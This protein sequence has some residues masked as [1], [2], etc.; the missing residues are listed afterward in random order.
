MKAL[1]D[2]DWVLEFNTIFATHQSETTLSRAR[3]GNHTAAFIRYL[4]R[5]TEGATV[6]CLQYQGP[7]EGSS[8][9]AE[10]PTRLRVVFH[11]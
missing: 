3:F 2:P 9:V 4:I 11:W 1:S 10:R 6:F 5:E 7:D 8:M